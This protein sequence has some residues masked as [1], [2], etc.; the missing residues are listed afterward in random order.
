MGMAIRTL[1]AK[2]K[3]EEDGLEDLRIRCVFWSG[4]FWP[5][6]QFTPLTPPP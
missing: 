1:K 5:P 4:K 3:A 2:Y 6:L